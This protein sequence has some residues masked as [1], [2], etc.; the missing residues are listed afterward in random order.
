MADRMAIMD[1]GRIE[2]IGT[3]E[4]VY[5]GPQSRFIADFIGSVT[6]LEGTVEKHG[7]GSVDIAAKDGF[8]IRVRTDAKPKTG[9]VV[10]FAVRPEKLRIATTPP[11]DSKV[12]AVEGEIWDVAYL[13]DMTVYHVRLDGG[14]I[15]RVS[16]LNATR[17]GPGSLTWHD[18]AWVSFADDAGIIL[19]R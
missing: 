8:T 1:K 13:G 16:Q 2:Q 11:T 18:R 7:A 12:N 9:S 3:P 15:L 5:E 4:E 6:M 14:Q 17:A 19:E 10:W